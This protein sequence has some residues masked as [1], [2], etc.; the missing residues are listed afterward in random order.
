MR[1]AG[2]A[3]VDALAVLRDAARLLVAHWPVL[4]VL[5][6]LG[7]MLRNASLWAALVTSRHEPWVAT[8]IVPL[9]PLFTLVAL[10]LMLRALTPSLDHVGG[11][12]GAPSLM[13][14][15]GVAE[16]GRR[17]GRRAIART[18]AVVND[19]LA[20]LAGT[21][22]PFI[23]VYAVQG[24][25][26]ED[27]NQF[28][29]ESFA[30]EWFNQS[31]VFDDV[32]MQARTVADESAFWIGAVVVLALVLRWLVDAF[33][34][35][36]RG[37]GW[38]LFAAWLEVTWLTWLAA[39]FSHQWRQIREWAADRVIL[40]WIAGWWA[41]LTG[42]LGPVGAAMEGARSW[43]WGLLGDFDALVVV[44]LAWLAIGAVAY[45]RTLPPAGK[46]EI[47]AVEK[48]QQRLKARAGDRWERQVKGRWSILPDWLRS[49]LARPVNSV[50]GR[51]G[52]L[53]RGLGTLAA[54]G[55]V[56]MLLFC[57]VFLLTRQI[58]GLVIEGLRW[59]VGPQ[60]PQVMIHFH[61]Y[62][63]LA[64]NLVTTVLQV[65]LL[66]AAIDRMMMRWDESAAEAAEAGGAAGRP[67]GTA[68]PAADG[69]RPAEPLPATVA[70]P[71]PTPARQWI[72]ALR[73][74]QPPDGA[75]G[76]DYSPGS[77]SSTGNDT[78]T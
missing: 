76:R 35:P 7:A 69:Q 71:P 20:L 63:D 11:P 27:R 56:P 37:T 21:L 9:A 8:F 66:A 32:A 12:A 41:A 68:G 22:V 65:V 13:E 60:D 26:I 61:P 75:T 2:R 42:W 48:Y 49:W 72:E 53:A 23:T 67:A 43:V 77:D 3:V 19:R 15:A 51:F 38:G 54:A 45:S 25:L 18:R 58:S 31:N 59:V 5:F 36:K 10:I 50:T 28:V 39:L 1:G 40:E 57:L 64:A 4:V 47:P 46:H 62:L 24:Y 14:S 33:D 34:L 16:P 29:N 70:A 73:Q 74:T 6:L 78:S 44:P 55:L 30:D 52:G 17:R